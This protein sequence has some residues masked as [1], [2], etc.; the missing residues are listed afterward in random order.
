[1]IRELHFTETVDGVTYTAVTSMPAGARLLD[2]LIETYTGWTAATA[3]LDLGDSDAND[4]LAAAVD[5]TG[6]MGVAGNGAG[7]TDWGN[8]LSDSDG[9]YSAGGPGKLY[10]NGDLITAVV[11][12]G[13]PGGPTGFSRVS[14]L[15]ELRGV[16]NPATVV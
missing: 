14:L 2:I 1:M 15:L 8:G 6:Q 4:A 7:G 12:A 9:P 11:T 5:L 3:D 13:T 16:S 10:P